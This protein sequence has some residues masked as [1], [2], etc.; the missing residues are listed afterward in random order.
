MKRLFDERQE[1]E[2]LKVK[3]LEMHV[4]LWILAI[5]LVIKSYVM[6]LPVGYYITECV[7]LLVVAVIEWKLEA[8]RGRF[9]PYFKPTGKNCL[10][11]SLAGAAPFA[12]AHGIGKWFQY[13]EYP[14]GVLAS[15]LVTFLM[16]FAAIYFALL[17]MAIYSKGKQKK[18]DEEL[19]AEENGEE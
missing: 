10:L 17:G 4:V 1:Q 13:P 2:H 18:L 11:L 8:G 15:T 9:D 16:L 5:S 14:A 12:I 19:E 3:R 6:N 7:V